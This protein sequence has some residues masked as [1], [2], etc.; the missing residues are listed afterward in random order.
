LFFSGC[1]F[2]WYAIEQELRTRR[3]QKKSP[4]RSEGDGRAQLLPGDLQQFDGA[5]VPIPVQARELQQ[6]IQASYESAS[7]RCFWV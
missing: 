2:Q 6:D 3:A 4:F 1:A 7:C 5:R